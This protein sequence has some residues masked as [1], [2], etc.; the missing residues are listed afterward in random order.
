MNKK[1][2]TKR[3]I[4]LICIIIVVALLAAMPLLA[5]Q[6]E[7][8]DGPTASILSGT[9]SAGSIH[10]ELIGGGTLAEEDAVTIDLPSAVKLKEFLVANGDAVTEGTAI[11]TV[12]RVTVMTA[13]SQVQDT[14]DYLSE[15]I[16]DASDTDSEESVAALA[17]GIV[18]ILYAGEGDSVQNVMLEHGALAVL[19]LDGLMAVDMETESTLPVGTAVTV[20]LSDGTEASGKI[21]KNLAGEMTVTVED[22]SYP[23]G[24]AVTVT[25]EDGTAVGSGQLYIYSPWNAT[26]YAGTVDTIKV[27]V[28]D[29]LSAGKTIMVL[30]DVGYS[31][32]YQQLT[33]TRQEYEELML[34]LFQMYQTETITAPCD[35]VVSGVDED[36]AFLLS[37]NGDNWTVNLLSFFGA[38]AHNGYFAYAAQVEEATENGMVLLMSPQRHNIAD[39]TQLSAI[40]ADISAMDSP[41]TYSG[42][43]TVYTQDENGLLQK[44]GRAEVGDLILAVGDEAQ[45]QWFIALDGVNTAPQQA[46]AENENRNG[47][48]ALLSN[49]EPGPEPES[50]PKPEPDSTPAPEPDSTPAP[51][52]DSTPEPEPEPEPAPEPDASEED[53]YYGYV[54]QVVE[55]VDGI[56]KVKQT[57]YTYTITDLNNLPAVSVD[58]NALTQ[59][60]TYDI[61]QMAVPAP[62]INDYLLLLVA[63]DG[64]LKHF[65]KQ[66]L[67]ISGGQTDIP[68]D[69]SG[70]GGSFGG[71]FG[72]SGGSAV[73]Q[74]PAFEPY[75][76]EMTEIAAVT[77]QS[78]ITLDITVDELDMHSVYLGMTAQVKIDALGG[79]KYTATIT[80]IGNTGANN[81]GN[82][83]FTVELTMDRTDNMLSGMNA[84]A[85]IVL[86]TASDVLTI[87]ADALVENGNQT[88]VY[89][90]YDEENDTLL[91][92][93]TVKVGCSDGETVEILEGLA[94]GQT[95]YYAYYDTLEISFI[96]DFGGGGFMFG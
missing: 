57:A 56:M 83:K 19:S 71:S 2:N 63:R 28:G 62:A 88:I 45:V 79:E 17:G 65:V 11:A 53:A 59:E 35:G 5:K 16:E 72:G 27:S 38:K 52:P 95:Y 85:T 50:E 84:T 42:D 30:R 21:V 91:D 13:I 1:K 36:G 60:A 90:G 23:V 40:P 76:L 22:D 64:T 77:P 18:K 69:L 34:D 7:N 47:F 12:D 15:Q 86:S 14:L 58:T 74:E 41:W 87:P 73:Q 96:P 54:A 32:S 9:V 78:T 20:T 92:P 61:S 49:S 46:A 24:D 55:I 51:E 29:E 39:L 37:D 93:V 94:N 89:T 33:S 67:P 80:E 68:S 82:S 4:K 10:T 43:T 44:S 81:G 75:S 48:L 31:A 66:Q 26:A 8:E 6:D 3:L 70:M 25:A